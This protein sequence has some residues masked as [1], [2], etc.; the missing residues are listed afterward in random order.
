MADKLLNVIILSPKKTLFQGKAERVILPGENGVFE[1][2]PF[3]KRLLSRLLTGTVIV[4]G[5]MIPIYRGVVQ[6]GGNKVTIIIE[7]EKK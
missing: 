2:L 4:D 7:E 3:H 1:V 5:Q 6:V